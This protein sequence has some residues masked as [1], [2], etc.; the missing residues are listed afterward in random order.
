LV[1][2]LQFLTSNN[3]TSFFN[4]NLGSRSLVALLL[5]LESTLMLLKFSLF[6]V[7]PVLGITVLFTSLIDQ[8]ISLATVLNGILP[9]KVK[10][11]AL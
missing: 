5:T 7:E 4:G 6:P 8:F 2:P 3:E 10:L 11:M 1:G 9:L